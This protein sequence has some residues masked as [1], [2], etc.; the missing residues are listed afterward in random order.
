MRILVLSDIHANLEALN[1]VLEDAGQVDEVWCLGDLVGYGPDPNECVETIRGLSKVTCL[2]GN[3]DAAVLGQLDLAAFNR[4]AYTSV[5]WTKEVLSAEN[6]DFLG[7]LPDRVEFPSVT[8]SHGSPRNPIWEYLLDVNTVLS[9]FAYFKTSFCFV[10]HTHIPIQYFY[11]GN[12][13]VDW[14]VPK[15]GESMVLASQSI[16]NPGSVGQPRD[17]DPRAAYAIFDTQEMK[18]TPRRIIYNVRAVQQRI[19]KAGLPARHAARL[20]EGW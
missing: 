19:T 13:H 6:K 3:H 20:E 4:E 15:P 1:T 16:M 2:K 14:I 8:L 12:G 9:N 10:G 5:K 17:R 18:W 11:N 7:T